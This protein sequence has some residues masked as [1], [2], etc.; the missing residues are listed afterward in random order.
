MLIILS[1]LTLKVNISFLLATRLTGK[2]KYSSGISIASIGF[3]AVTFPSRGTDT[4]VSSFL[5]YSFGTRSS[6]VLFFSGSLVIKPFW[7]RV[8]KCVWTVAVL[9]KLVALHNSLTVGG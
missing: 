2:S 1:P 6:I 8:F 3:P 5:A 9:F 4:T 7:T